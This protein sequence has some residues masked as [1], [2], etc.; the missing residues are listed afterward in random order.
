MSPSFD[1]YITQPL[2]ADVLHT[3]Q[4]NTANNARK[5][6]ATSPIM[7]VVCNIH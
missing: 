2:H 7:D 3:E 5:P 4:K 1:R 6:K